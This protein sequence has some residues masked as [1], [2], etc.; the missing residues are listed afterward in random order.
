M[1]G[2]IQLTLNIKQ[3]TFNSRCV[4]K[5]SSKLVPSALSLTSVSKFRRRKVRRGSQTCSNACKL[6]WKGEQE[7]HCISARIVKE[8]IFI[9]K[10]LHKNIFVNTFIVCEQ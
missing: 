9:T 5:L 6:V 10:G 8:V 2:S 1:P 3:P 7:S 4:C